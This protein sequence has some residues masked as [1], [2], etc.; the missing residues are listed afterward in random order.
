[1]QINADINFL[2]AATHLFGALSGIPAPPVC[3]T[4]GNF[5]TNI[6]CFRQ[7]LFLR[8]RHEALSF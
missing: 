3:V 8:K 2:R 4:L 7:F 1:M 5:S 6:D